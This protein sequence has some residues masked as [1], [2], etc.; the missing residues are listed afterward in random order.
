MGLKEIV[1]EGVDFNHVTEDTEIVFNKRAYQRG[2][3]R[4]NNKEC[5][6]SGKNYSSVILTDNVR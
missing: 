5:E 3:R 4:V 2:K 1:R 6:G